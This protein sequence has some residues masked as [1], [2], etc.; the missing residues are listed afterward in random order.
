LIE[1]SVVVLGFNSRARGRGRRGTLPGSLPRVRARFQPHRVRR[2]E[3]EDIE[4]PPWTR[5]DLRGLS[6]PRTQ[7]GVSRPPVSNKRCGTCSAL[8]KE[9]NRHFEAIRNGPDATRFG[10][11]SEL[12]VSLLNGDSSKKACLCPKGIHKSAQGL[13]DPPVTPQTS[14][15]S[16]ESGN[17]SF[18]TCVTSI[19]SLCRLAG[20]DFFFWFPTNRFV[21]RLI[22]NDARERH[23]DWR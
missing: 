14:N 16:Q 21:L 22:D 13:P 19:V 5:G 15:L 11:A 18:K 23:L 9:G 7:G 17:L 12:S 4:V 6:A 1:R 2:G 3:R 8:A 10:V 20:H